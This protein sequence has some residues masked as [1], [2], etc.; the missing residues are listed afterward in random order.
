MMFSRRM[1]GLVSKRQTIQRTSL[2]GFVLVGLLLLTVVLMGCAP[3]GPAAAPTM[4]GV[5]MRVGYFPNITHAQAVIGI[6]D[7]TFQRALGSQAKLDVKL[8]NAGP[9]AIEALF[10]G[11]LDLSYIGP[12]PAINGY[13][14]SNG[15]ALRIVAGATSGGAVLVV[16]G[17]SGITQVSDFAGKRIASPQLGNTQDVALRSWLAK[18]GIT[19]KERGGATQVIPV[20]NPDI[21][22]LFQK[23]ELDAAWVPE[24]WG[25]RLVREANAKIFLDERDLWPNG[26][27]TTALVIVSTKFLKEHPDLVKL[28]L[29]THVELSQRITADPAS[30]KKQVN[31]EIGRITHAELPAEVLDDAWSRQVITYD[32]VTSSVLGSAEAAFRAGYL[33]DA[34][35]KLDTIT[36]LALLNQVLTEKNLEPVK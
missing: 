13:V 20:A 28:W 2:R 25:A 35:P 16:R 24:P 26:Q 15:Q 17:D 21:L 22:T 29:Q 7:G 8:F 33:G 34:M 3:A 11:Q 23:K 10:A 19:L 31:A 12:N 5:T 9:S 30:A 14:K 27:F 32:P 1:S 18:Q 36:D 4:G 6:A